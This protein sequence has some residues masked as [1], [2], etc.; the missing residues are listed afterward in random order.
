MLSRVAPLD[1][2]EGFVSED[3]SGRKA[4]DRAAPRMIIRVKRY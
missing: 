1:T 4:G 2:A 3:W